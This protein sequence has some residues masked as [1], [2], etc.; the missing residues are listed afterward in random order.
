[1]HGMQEV[2]G[3][4]PSGSTNKIKW[5]PSNHNPHV[6]LGGPAGNT[7]RF[8]TALRL[9]AALF[10]A[11]ANDHRLRLSAH[12][13][14]DRK[15]GS[16]VRLMADV[17]RE[18]HE[19]LTRRVCENEET[20][21]NYASAAELLQRESA[22]L[23]KIARLQRWKGWTINQGDIVSPDGWTINRNQALTVP[24]LHGQIS[25]LR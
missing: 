3:S 8:W 16:A 22:H 12:R 7:G 9:L 25:T 5:L 17:L 13:D 21:K 1:L 14:W 4:I 20:A 19:A 11:V 23:R 10:R 24:L 2:D 15:R 18:D 6:P